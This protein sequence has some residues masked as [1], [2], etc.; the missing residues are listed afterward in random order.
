MFE[1]LSAFK[2]AIKEVCE[3]NLAENTDDD[4]FAGLFDPTVR[5]GR[6]ELPPF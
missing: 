6:S 2:S 1:V 5:R 3:K 4:V